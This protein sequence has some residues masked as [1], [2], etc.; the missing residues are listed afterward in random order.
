MALVWQPIDVDTDPDD[1]LPLTA[2]PAGMVDALAE[3]LAAFER[4][5][6]H[7]EAACRGMGPDLFFPARGQSTAEAKA[8]CHRCPV[9]AECLT[10]GLGEKH[11]IWGGSSE[12]G[13]RQLRKSTTVDT[14]A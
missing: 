8:L 3:L 6:W 4:P 7:A 2:D 10:A 13:R 9:Q 11:G 12:R 5:A 14:A 1:P